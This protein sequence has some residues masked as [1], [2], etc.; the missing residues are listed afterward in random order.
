MSAY[1]FSANVMSFLKRA[2]IAIT[3]TLLCNQM[4]STVVAHE[5]QQ[6]FKFKFYIIQNKKIF[7]NRN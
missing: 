1:I 7:I 4:C 5:E 3:F 2:A 6:L